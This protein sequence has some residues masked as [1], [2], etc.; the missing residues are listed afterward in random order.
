M[1]VSVVWLEALSLLTLPPPQGEGSDSPPPLRGRV[2]WGVSKLLNS[3]N[4]G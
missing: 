4:P 2:G 3:S 1:R